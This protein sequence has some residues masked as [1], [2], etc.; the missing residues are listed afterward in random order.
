MA[1]YGKLWSSYFIDLLFIAIN[2]STQN[3]SWYHHEHVCHDI[4]VNCCFISEFKPA[5]TDFFATTTTHQHHLANGFSLF[6]FL[7]CEVNICV[8]LLHDAGQLLC[9]W[10]MMIVHCYLPHLEKEIIAA[11]RWDLQSRHPLQNV[12][13]TKEDPILV[14]P[15]V[16][17]SWRSANSPQRAAE[18]STV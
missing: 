1:D 7:C 8:C 17:V 10:S 15:L 6:K 4:L 12:Q 16:A 11:L 3:T 2:V 13:L 9:S 14:E 18:W 5:I